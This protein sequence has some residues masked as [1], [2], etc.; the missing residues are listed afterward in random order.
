M[1]SPIRSFNQLLVR[2]CFNLNVMDISVQAS[3]VETRALA[4]KKLLS[5]YSV[6][7]HLR[8]LKQIKIL[9]VTTAESTRNEEDWRGA[10]RKSNTMTLWFH[11]RSFATAVREGVRWVSCKLQSISQG[12]WRRLAPC[13]SQRIGSPWPCA[14]VVFHHSS[15]HWDRISDE[16]PM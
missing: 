2:C 8:R 1:D 14:F 13:W 16:I 12:L 5:S 7:S 10:A 6:I 15:P 3:L 9:L 4:S 11:L